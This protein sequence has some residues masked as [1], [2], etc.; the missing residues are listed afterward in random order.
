MVSLST[1]ALSLLIWGSFTM[2]PLAFALPSILLSQF[3]HASPASLLP[4]YDVSAR[5]SD[6]GHDKLG[7]VASE[8]SIC[9]DSA[10]ISRPEG[11]SNHVAATWSLTWRPRHGFTHIRL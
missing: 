9:S 6:P 3:T 8:S 11:D 1:L 2:R 10:C 4:E 5:V 7:A